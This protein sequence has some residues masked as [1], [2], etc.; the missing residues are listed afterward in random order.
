MQQNQD[1]K[2]LSNKNCFWGL[3]D[4]RALPWRLTKYLLFPYL[5]KLENA[6]ICVGFWMAHFYF[7][8]FV[9]L[10]SFLFSF[11]LFVGWIFLEIMKDLYIFC[12]F[13]KNFREWKL[14]VSFN[15][16]EGEGGNFTPC[17]FSPNNSEMVKDLILQSVATH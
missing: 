13:N 11:T 7:I 5:I 15:L 2:K 10:S 6:Y 4:L 1:R 16:G 12:S 8:Y 3:A 14:F 9:K 17:W